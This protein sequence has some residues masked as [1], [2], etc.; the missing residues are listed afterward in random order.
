MTRMLYTGC[1]MK[2]KLLFPVVLTGICLALTACRKHTPSAEGTSAQNFSQPPIEN[3][4]KPE[5]ASVL[6]GD[7]KG[8][9]QIQ[10]TKLR[11]V[12]HVVKQADSLSATLDSPDQG[13]KDIPANAIQY[14][15]PHVKIQWQGIGGSFDGALEGGKLSGTWQ[16]GAVK[17]PLVF[18]RD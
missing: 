13:A 18:E 15:P 5:Q 14:A 2:T 17:I 16:Q 11:V 8:T 12:L 9:L 6:E 10:Q 7:W 3:N 1:T 4:Y